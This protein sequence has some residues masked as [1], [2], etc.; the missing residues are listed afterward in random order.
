[1]KTVVY[2]GADRALN[3]A[4]QT[5][6]ARTFS[7]NQSKEHEEANEALFCY[8]LIKNLNREY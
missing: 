3:F 5:M 4:E 1:M 8:L 2:V 7:S 6:I